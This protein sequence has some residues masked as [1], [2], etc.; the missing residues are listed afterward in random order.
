M[1]Q[2]NENGRKRKNSSER[3]KDIMKEK[4]KNGRLTKKIT[5]IKTEGKYENS[6]RK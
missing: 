5:R 4:E 3:N 6:E 1:S 2:E